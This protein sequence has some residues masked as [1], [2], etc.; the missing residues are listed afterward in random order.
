MVPTWLPALD[1]SV[2]FAGHGWNALSGTSTLTTTDVGKQLQ[3][4]QLRL[5]PYFHAAQKIKIQLL[6]RIHDEYVSKA[7]LKQQ[8]PEEVMSV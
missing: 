2:L 6:L 7:Y 8:E 5:L 1:W 4:L 3:Q